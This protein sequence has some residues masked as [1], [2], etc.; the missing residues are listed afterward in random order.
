M[1]PR[2]WPAWSWSWRPGRWA[3]KRRGAD[4]DVFD[5]QGGLGG[6]QRHALTLGRHDGHDM[7]EAAIGLAGGGEALPVRDRDLDR[8][9]RTGHQDR[10]GDHQAARHLSLDHV[11][12]AQAQD[13][14]LEHHAEDLGEGADAGRGLAGDQAVVDVTDMHLVV[15]LGQE[16]Q[17]A[18]GADRLRIAAAGLGH[19]VALG[20]AL[21]HLEGGPL[22]LASV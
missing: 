1:R 13:G 17:H 7:R 20:A 9:E 19:G 2:P 4:I 18:V 10:A 21:G 11:I 15:A 6:R 22:L 14:R 3:A 12:G 5:R 16:A 8:S